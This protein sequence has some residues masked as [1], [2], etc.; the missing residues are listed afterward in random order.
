MRE[1]RQFLVL[2]HLSQLVTLIIGCGSLILPLIL[3]LTQKD[4]IYQMDAQGKTIVN[5]QLSIVVLYIVCVPLILLFGLGLLG[6][7]V[8]GLV[9][10]IYPV[11]NAI[12]VSN[13]EEPH[14]PLSFNFIS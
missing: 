3:W 5:F 12:K 10:I 9:S 1:D 8:L 7:L 14:Y 11:I 13:G 2:T 6:W 4:K